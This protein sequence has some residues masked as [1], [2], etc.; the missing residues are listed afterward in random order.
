MNMT[1]KQFKPMNRMPISFDD[2]KNIDKMIPL[3]A[4]LATESGQ[5]VSALQAWLKTHDL[6]NMNSE[7]ID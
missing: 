7:A 6:K 2:A 4:K 3:I 1:F 5:N